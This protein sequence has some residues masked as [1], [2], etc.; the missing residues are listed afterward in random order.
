MADEH[1]YWVLVDLRWMDDA[2]FDR[3]MR[4]VFQ[5]LPAPIR[6][7]AIPV[8]RRKIRNALRAQGMGRH[9][10]AEIDRLGARSIDAIADYLGDK[11]FFMGAEPTAADATL[12]PCV[13]AIL[14]PTFEVAVRNA[15]ERHRKS[16]GLRRSDDRTLLS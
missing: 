12:Y 10:R 7:I 5:K 15:A 16:D 6:A 8:I 4:Q 13:A 2:N 14:C 3:G 11:P 9:A 1:L